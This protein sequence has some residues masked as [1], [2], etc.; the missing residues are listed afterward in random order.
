MPVKGAYLAIAGGGAIL[1]WSGLR[2]KSWT[3]VIRDLVAGKNPQLSAAANPI[4]TASSPAGSASGGAAGGSYAA[5]GAGDQPANASE[6]AWIKALLLGIGAPAT[7]AN[8][9]SIAAWIHHENT[10][11]PPSASNNPLNTTLS[12]PGAS[13]FNSVGVKNYP[14]ALVG[15]AATVS[16]LQSGA[17]AQIVRDLQGGGGLCGKSYGGLSTWSGGGYSTVC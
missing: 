9:N 5:L 16:T 11:W 17:Y 8:V 4:M 10:G 13:S 15:I 14:S 1:L 7:T 12:A 2:G 3:A 6:T